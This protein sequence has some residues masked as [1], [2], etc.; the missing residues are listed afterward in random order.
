MGNGSVTLLAAPAIGAVEDGG[1]H[2]GSPGG[3]NLG[4]LRCGGQNV[5]RVTPAAEGLIDGDDVRDWDARCQYGNHRGADSGVVASTVGAVVP[6][7]AG[8]GVIPIEINVSVGRVVAAANSEIGAVRIAHVLE[9]DERLGPGI[10]GMDPV[11][12][13]FE[14]GLGTIRPVYACRVRVRL[15]HEV[16][17]EHFGVAD[18]WGYGR[19]EG[20]SC[21]SALTNPYETVVPAGQAVEKTKVADIGKVEAVAPGH[22]CARGIEVAVGRVVPC[23][24]RTRR[25]AGTWCGRR[26]RRGNGTGRWWR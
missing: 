3:E 23:R 2:E 18:K 7:A 26:T 19:R 14:V 8:V 6:R 13:R 24:P 17:T 15:V 22:E 16:E 4:F 20:G 1:G 21:S 12:L 11:G 25:W 5:S 9:H 10:I